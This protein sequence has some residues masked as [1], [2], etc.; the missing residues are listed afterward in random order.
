[1]TKIIAELCQN[2]NGDIN[3]LSE[4][5][6]AASESG[7]D[8]VKIQSMHSK[9][10]TYRERFENGLVEGGKTKVIKRPFKAELERLS[11][12]D[13]DFDTHSKF[14]ELCEK[15]KLIPMTTIFSFNNI[16]FLKQFK[17]L[18]YIKVASFDC[19]SHALIKKIC[20][21]FKNKKIIVSTGT[22]YDREIDKTKKILE[23]ENADYALLH[24]ISIY[25]TPIY[26]A[27]LNRIDYLRKKTQVVGL[28]D[29]SDPEK[30]NNI[31]PAAGFLKKIDYL[32][33]HF[34]ILDKKKT[35]DGPVSV[36]PKQLEE[37]VKLSKMNDESLKEY[38]NDKGVNLEKI[39]GSETR[40]LS[41]TEL[42]NRDYYQGRFAYKDRNNHTWF[43][44]DENYK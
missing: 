6:A 18:N 23:D 15:Y 34:S 27:N 42:L 3:I 20:K 38:L 2:H 32:E 43:N 16:D 4:M 7:A 12:L 8:I 10:L 33:K 24:C 31:I 11:K 35:K 25:P 36:S 22:A 28:S 44:W 40:E 17:N 13:L 19:N 14:F 9:D 26:H 41:D 5:V 39:F 1:M 29:H 37:I 21:N 30:D